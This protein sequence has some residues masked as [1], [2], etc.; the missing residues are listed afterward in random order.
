MYQ[1]MRGAMAAD[2]A[3]LGAMAKGLVHQHQRQHG[4]DDG[5]GADAHARGRGAPWSPP[6]WAGL[7]GPRCGPGTMMLEVGLKATR[8]APA[9]RW[10]CRRGCRRH[11]WKKAVGCQF[12]AM[13]AALLRHG[14]ET[15]TDLH[16]L[17]RVDGHHCRGQLGVELAVDRLAPAR[18]HALGDPRSTR[19]P[20]ESPDLR[21]AFMYCSSCGNHAGIGPEE[22]LSST[23]LPVE[24]PGRIRPDPARQ[25]AHAHPCCSASH[26]LAITAAATR[27]VVSRA[28]LRP[29]PRGSRMPY[30]CQ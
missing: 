25:A 3:A 1:A 4:L 7:P 24:C 29:P 11:D 18:R 28:E 16:A 26:F 19:A 12:V 22:R 27:M 20:T 8:T 30:L 23:V 10:R 13:L 6:R 2:I 9:V 15:G 21:N 17:D 5:R 14:I